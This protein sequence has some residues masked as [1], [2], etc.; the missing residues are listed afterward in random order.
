MPTAEGGGCPS[1]E[2]VWARWTAGF[3]YVT[4]FRTVRAGLR[5]L[6][7]DRSIRRIWLPAY[8]CGSAVPTEVPL[9]WIPVGRTLDLD[10]DALAPELRSG[11][12]VM[13]ID[14]FGRSPA[15]AL[16]A[17]AAARPDV[18]WIEDRAQALWPDR[19]PFGEVVLYS[20][21]KLLGVADGGVLVS[22]APLP[23]P[24]A[25]TELPGLWHSNDARRADPDG[26]TPDTWFPGFRVREDEFT[27][28]PAPMSDRTHSLL[29]SIALAPEAEIRQ[30]NWLMLAQLLPDYALWPEQHPAFVPLAFPVVVENAGNAA[31]CMAAQ[32]VWCARHWADLPSDADEFPE[33]HTLAAQCLSLPLDSRYDAEDMARV[34][35]ALRA[36]ARKHS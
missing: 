11:D 24:N 21:R 33:A 9:A 20:P 8:I 34:A 12:A 25:D 2:S 29:Q 4:G 28:A 35:A 31:S 27:S 23:Q 10:V 19:A 16:I 3:S 6:L 26:R 14:Y 5:A 36:V 32:R 18:L 1:G 17:L 7:R 15:S 22:R 13:I 30:A